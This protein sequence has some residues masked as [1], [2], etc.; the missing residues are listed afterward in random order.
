MLVENQIRVGDVAQI[1]GTGG[2]VEEV[3]LRTTVLRG[4]DGTVHVFPNGTVS[5]LSNMT[6]GFSFHVFELGVAYKEDTDRVVDVI[7]EVGGRMR[8]EEPFQT[9][10]LE[11]AEV[12]GVDKFDDS[13]VVIKGRLKTQPGQQWMVGREFNR[14][15]K[16]RF[17]EL[18]IEI[19]FPHRSIYFGEASAPFALSLNATDRDTVKS[20]VR[21]VLQESRPATEGAAA[22]RSCS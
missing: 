18:G 22:P 6:R 4:L 7:R 1:N 8:E 21:E 19:P 3:N 16:K 15:I 2:L 11:P 10:I 5:T 9:V 12:L 20:L 14:R 13:A 17:D